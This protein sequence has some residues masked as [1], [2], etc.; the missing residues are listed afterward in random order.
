LSLFFNDWQEQFSLQ[1][2]G[3]R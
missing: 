1:H 2:E 3:T